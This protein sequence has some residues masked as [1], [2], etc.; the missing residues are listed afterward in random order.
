[1]HFSAFL[2]FAW[3]R[4]LFPMRWLAALGSE[5][6]DQGGHVTVVYWVAAAT[7]LLSAVEAAG[8]LARE[9]LPALAALALSMTALSASLAL[10]A[11]DPAVLAGE[12]GPVAWACAGLG[13]V[14]TWSFARVLSA[15]RGDAR[16][17]TGMMAIPLLG[18][19]WA[20]VLLLGLRWAGSHGTAGAGSSALAAIGTQLT[21][22]AYY[23]PGLCQVAFLAWQRAIVTPPSW[24]RTAMQAVCAAAAAEFVL[25]LARSAILIARVSGMQ[26]GGPATTVIGALQGIAAICG[27]GALAVGPVAAPVSAR[28]WPWLAYWRLRPLWALLRTAVPDAEQTAACGTRLSIRSRL[29]RR[30]A[31][32]RDAEQLLSAYWRED[33]AARARAAAQSAALSPD[34]EQAV[35]EAAV[36]LNAAGARLRGEP[37]ASEPLTVEQIRGNGGAD[38]HS[39]IT[40]LVRVSRAVRS[41]AIIHGLTADPAP[42]RSA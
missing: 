30:V 16:S 42:Q 25:T 32:I 13:I 21:L 39:E 35:I 1:V 9:R 18:G 15:G 10:A 4:T 36:L 8:E 41:R 37:P 17:V 20:I 22:L 34:L 2:S 27:I 26:A 28:C 29:Q 11:A 38:L 7:A 33:V 19:A 14:G 6:R 40:R 12:S 31:G 3:R 5:F 23:V 24:A